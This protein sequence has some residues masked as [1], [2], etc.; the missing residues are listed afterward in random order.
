MVALTLA[1]AL[2]DALALASVTEAVQ[3]DEAMPDEGSE[4]SLGL[5][6]AD[7]SMAVAE[8]EDEIPE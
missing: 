6:E 5:I 2:S 1:L 3:L 7:D 8:G 4:D